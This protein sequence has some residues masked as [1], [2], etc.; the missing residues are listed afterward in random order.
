MH[1]MLGRDELCASVRQCL[2]ILTKAQEKLEGISS[3]PSTI[4]DI[5]TLFGGF[6]SGLDKLDCKQA[7]CATA[8]DGK[9]AIIA[10]MAIK[11]K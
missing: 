9:I 1:R 6:L 4:S 11:D 5:V 3:P 8:N 2:A 10:L 7:T